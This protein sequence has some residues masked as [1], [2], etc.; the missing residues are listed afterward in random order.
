MPFAWL[1]W[2]CVIG[3]NEFFSFL[4]NVGMEIETVAHNDKKEIV[5]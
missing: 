2:F 4:R 3:Q 1:N 5:N